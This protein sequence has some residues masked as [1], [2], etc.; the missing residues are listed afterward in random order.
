M[1]NG[2]NRW[3]L[4]REGGF[5]PL[6]RFG[7]GFLLGV[8]LKEPKEA[9]NCASVTRDCNIGASVLELLA[10]RFA[11]IEG[12][13][14]LDYV[15]ETKFADGQGYYLLKPGEIIIYPDNNAGLEPKMINLI[16]LARED[17]F[18][19]R[20]GVHTIN[21]SANAGFYSSSFGNVAYNLALD[22]PVNGFSIY[23][24]VKLP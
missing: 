19:A 22:R 4:L 24:I 13:Q 18:P 10:I 16:Q 6:S 12:A 2:K 15:S 23:R 5:Q 7:Q 20:F 8:K 21:K 3:Y 17:S 1:S 9:V 14:P 11:F